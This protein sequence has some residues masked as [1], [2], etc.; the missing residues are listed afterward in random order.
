MIV[1]IFTAVLFYIVPVGKIGAVLAS[2]PLTL[3]GPLFSDG[4]F[5]ALIAPILFSL[6][7][8]DLAQRCFA[9]K[10]KRVASIS[11]FLAATFLLIYAFVP[12]I[13]GMYTKELGIAY[14]AGQSPLV[15]LFES[16]LSTTGMTLVA[17]ALLAAICSTADS[18]LGAAGSNLVADI[19]PTNNRFSLSFSRAMTMLVGICALV[20]A[21]NFDD[22]ISIIVKS[23]EISLAALF[24][25][26]ILAM[27]VKEPSKMGAKL[28]VAFGMLTFLVV[29]LCAPPFP[30]TLLALVISALAFS[31]GAVVDKSRRAA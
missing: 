13:F 19:L 28:A 11:A 12:I 10:T 2:Q 16:K 4:F 27:Y 17:C 21:F 5:A 1:V 3:D 14:D 26:L 18:L 31:V 8:Q 15:L 20:I 6:I 7:E 24:V 29:N 22:V 25:P 9:A 23:Y 30:P